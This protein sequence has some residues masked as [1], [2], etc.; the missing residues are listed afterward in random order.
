[1]KMIVNKYIEN[2]VK[3]N[4]VIDLDELEEDCQR[5]NKSYRSPSK[6]VHQSAR[7]KMTDP[8]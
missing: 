3:K 6:D 7:I 8:E 2:V 4:K 1:M 5:T